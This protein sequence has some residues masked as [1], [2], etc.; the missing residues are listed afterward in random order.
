MATM[1]VFNSS[2]FSM[3]SLSGAVEKMDYV[4]NFLGSLGIFEPMPVRTRNIFV[5][6]RDST[7]TLIPESPLGGEPDERKH[8]DRSA[9]ALKARRLAKGFTLYAHEIDGIRAFGGE[10]EMERVQAELL[11]RMGSVRRDMEATHELHRLGA[12][13]GIL[14]DASG[15]TT[16]SYFTEFGVSQASAVNFA[17]GTA[18][19]DVRKKCADVI[20]AMERA[21]KGAMV[22]GATVHA[23]CGDSFYDQLIDHPKVRDTY[24]NF[25]AAAALREPTPFRSFS[26]GGITFHNYRGTD[27][28]STIAIAAAEAKFFPVGA[29]EVFKVAYAPAEFAP[30][31]NTLGQSIYAMTINDRDRQAWVRGEMYSY[32]LYFCQ[33]PEMLQR[34]TAT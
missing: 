4:P 27:D 8:D 7:L 25:V 2:A 11:R 31:V 13:Q 3:T 23:L 14:T 12:I 5:D 21:S 32:P 10:S 18:G 19:T 1:N 22:P 34:A 9:V 6:Q 28:N 26:F 33:R 29:P 30:F 17:L 15:D 16:Y 20:R 24:L